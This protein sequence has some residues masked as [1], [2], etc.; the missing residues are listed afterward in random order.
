MNNYQLAEK[1]I[2]LVYQ[3][4]SSF[5]RRNHNN[6]RLECDDLNDIGYT[7]L[8]IACEHYDSSLGIPFEHYA[9]R[10]IRRAMIKQIST[11]FQNNIVYFDDNESLQDHPCCNWDAENNHLLETLQDGLN[12]L[13]LGE[14]HLIENRFGYYSSPMKLKELGK[15]MNVSFQAVDK[16]LKR[17]LNKLHRYIDENRYTY[18]N[19]A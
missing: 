6:P 11:V 2:N 1:H 14:R 9:S 4:S 19:C 18:S 3:L 8:L 7:A 17:I 13:T 10:T 16:K 5:M 15:I 12:S